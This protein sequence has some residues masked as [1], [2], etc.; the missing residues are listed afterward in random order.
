MGPGVPLPPS[1]DPRRGAGSGRAGSRRAGGGPS[2]RRTTRSGTAGRAPGRRAST[3]RVRLV[4]RVAAGL[5]SAAVLIAGGWLWTIVRVFDATVHRVEVIS[6]DSGPD[7]DGSDLN[8]LLVG[9]D[10]RGGLTAGELADVGTQAD[11]GF[12]TDTILLVHV[13]A[14]GTRATA[15]SF[16]RDL[17]VYIPVL[18]REGKINSAYANGAC[19]NNA[20]ASVLTPAQ[21]RAGTKSLIDTVSRFSGLRIDHYV[22]VGLYGFYSITKALGGIEVCLLHPAVDRYSAIDLPAGRQTI[23]GKQALAFVRQ[24]HGLP[25][26]AY[27]RIQRQ[28]YFLASVFRKLTSAGV[29][30][31]PLKQLALVRAVGSSLTMD[32][33]L[34]PLELARQLQ[35]LTAGNLQ[36]LTVPVTGTGQNAAGQAVDLTDSAAL[37]AFWDKV[38]GRSAPAAS[39]SPAVPRTQVS[40]TVRNGTGR[41]GLATQTATELQ[42]LGFTVPSTG[43]SEHRTGTVIEYGAGQEPAARTV[44]AVI[45]GAQLRAGGGGG[46]TLILGSDFAGLRTGAGSPPAGPTAPAG[47]GG[48]GSITPPPRTAAQTDCID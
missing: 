44:A 48:T 26:G 6:A 1:L 8:I 25:N 39:A 19:P 3:G 15:V 10:S 47:G 35:H 32:A 7:I 4:G 16:S 14:N 17:S 5:L 41:V 2:G 22:E 28:Q 42:Q 12:N 27:S 38:L 21:Q 37:P 23:S 24:R 46:V 9:N 43:N 11:A 36:F 40:V 13:P 29:L 18:G 30:V 20:C 33:G 45:P 31:D 34:D